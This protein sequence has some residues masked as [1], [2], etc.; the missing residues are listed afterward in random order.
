M[1]G[2]ERP[3]RRRGRRR[4][5]APERLIRARDARST[6]LGPDPHQARAVPAVTPT[7]HDV[8]EGRRPALG[9]D[10][11]DPLYVE[12]DPTGAQLTF[13]SPRTDPSYVSV[14]LREQ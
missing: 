10:T 9:I 14:P 13:S 5:H 4:R 7:A 12:H 11:A 8:T 3:G 2:Q 1:E 6:A